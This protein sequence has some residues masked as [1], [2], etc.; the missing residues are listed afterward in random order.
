MVADDSVPSANVTSIESAPATTCLAVRIWPLSSMT[1]PAPD[2]LSS[3]AP[4]PRWAWMYTID[5]WI[6][7][8]AVWPGGGTFWAAATALSTSVLIGARDL[9]GRQG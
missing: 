8:K 6:A 4:P 9:L 7:R 1:T 5:G 3:D 2:E